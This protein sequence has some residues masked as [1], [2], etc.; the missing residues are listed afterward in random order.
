MAV[1]DRPDVTLVALFDRALPQ[2][3]GYLVA[4]CG[5][6]AVAEDPDL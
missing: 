2:V 6:R 1:P 4:R 3:Y 5:D